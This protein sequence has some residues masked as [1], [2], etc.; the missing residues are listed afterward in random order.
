MAAGSS[1]WIVGLTH[2]LMFHLPSRGA[3]Q[4][5]AA[6]TLVP[7]WNTA[8][9]GATAVG[10]AASA[11]AAQLVPY[12]GAAFGV[13]TASAGGL[14]YLWRRTARERARSYAAR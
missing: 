10:A 8:V 13:V 2:W 3:I 14:Y 9:A 6:D 12:G 11:Q 4:A 7:S 5:F 1:A